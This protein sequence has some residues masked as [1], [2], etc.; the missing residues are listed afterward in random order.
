MNADPI[1]SEVYRMKAALA[2]EIGND[3]AKLVALLR[4]DAKKHPERMAKRVPV[5]R[6]RHTSTG[7]E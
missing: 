3:P 2:R 1:L 5:S 4:E 6:V 7:R